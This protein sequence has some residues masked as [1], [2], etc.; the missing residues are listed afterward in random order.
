MKK[1]F[2]KGT[3]HIIQRLYKKRV[4][5]K[6]NKENN[7]KIKVNDMRVRM[8]YFTDDITVIAKT[9]K[10]LGDELTKMNN[11]FKEYVRKLTEMSLRCDTRMVNPKCS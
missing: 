3:I 8:L 6:L 7:G 11:Y 10:E 2:E 9:E 1:K 4:K 5:K